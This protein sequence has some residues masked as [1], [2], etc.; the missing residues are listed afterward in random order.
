MGGSRKRIRIGLMALAVLAGG[1]GAAQAEC[2]AY[3]AQAT[4]DGWVSLKAPTAAQIAAGDAKNKS[5]WS[6]KLAKPACMT[7]SGTDAAIASLPR[8]ALVVSADQDKALRATFG[9][10]IQVA[11]TLKAAD[12]AKAGLPVVLEGAAL[13]GG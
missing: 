6:I 10:R 4:L 8:V 1:A 11:G 12:A 9:K 2:L 5:L 3:G 7:A 13:K